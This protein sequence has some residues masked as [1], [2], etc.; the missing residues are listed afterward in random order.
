MIANRLRALGGDVEFV[1]PADDARFED[2]PPQ[3]GRMVLARFRGTACGLGSADDKS[4]VAVG[5]V[6][7]FLLGYGRATPATNP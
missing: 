7:T 1:A 4:G 2:T 3:V 5:S 6:V